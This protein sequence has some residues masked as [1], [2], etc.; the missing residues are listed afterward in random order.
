MAI[1]WSNR[2]WPHPKR[3]PYILHS[4]YSFT[5][6]YGNMSR[7]LSTGISTLFELAIRKS[8]LPYMNHSR[9]VLNSKLIDFASAIQHDYP[10]LVH[11]RATTIVTTRP[12]VNGRSRYCLLPRLKETKTHWHAIYFSETVQLVDPE[13]WHPGRCGRRRRRILPVRLVRCHGGRRQVFLRVHRIRLN[14]HD[15]FV[16]FSFL[17]HDFMSIS[18]VSHVYICM[19]THTHTR[20]RLNSNGYPV[21]SFLFWIF[22][23]L[24][25]CPHFF[26]PKLASFSSP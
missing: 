7:G 24:I 19:C 22:D 3:I 8:R 2:N 21:F 11:R 20:N 14:C 17:F 6:L 4:D 10:L 13:G 25:S 9:V 16:K 18:V 15:W 1:I 26:P 12:T 23:L 5:F